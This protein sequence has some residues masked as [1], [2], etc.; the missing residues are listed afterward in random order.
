MNN[1]KSFFQVLRDH[2][3]TN[4]SL[5]ILLGFSILLIGYQLIDLFDYYGFDIQVLFIIAPFI[6]FAVL[7]LYY[8]HNKMSFAAHLIFFVGLL[9]PYIRNFYQMIFQTGTIN[10]TVFLTTTI[11]ALIAVY[12]ILKMIAH[13]REIKTY[14]PAIKRSILFLLAIVLIN[15]YLIE[16]L[17]QSL[18][19]LL[20]MGAALLT[21]GAKMSL[22]IVLMVYINKIVSAVYLAYI[23][24]NNLGNVNQT[25]LLINSIIYVLIIFYTVR[26]MREE[27]NVLYA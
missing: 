14:M 19:I 5:L 9:E 6:I 17:E 10:I 16:S 27:D 20:M 18:I 7:A 12:A 11:G 24:N 22:P 3:K 1:G 26:L 4:V 15:I 8:E 21:G 2:K 13:N 23:Y 25:N